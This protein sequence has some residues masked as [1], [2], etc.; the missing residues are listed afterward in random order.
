MKS[1]TLKEPVH[2]QDLS[3]IDILSEKEDY[4]SVEV[5]S[6]EYEEKM[7]NPVVS[8]NN[9]YSENQSL[10]LP[11]NKEIKLGCALNN[12]SSS[13]HMLGDTMKAIKLKQQIKQLKGK[14][15]KTESNSIVLK[16]EVQNLRN[17][18][19]TWIKRWQGLKEKKDRLKTLKKSWV[20]ANRKL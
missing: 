1:S 8:L 16:D 18:L 12:N 11:N 6:R 14:L 20:T 7:D 4:R 19:L 5:S 3:F 17:E 2:T 13:E 9:D 10:I 15:E